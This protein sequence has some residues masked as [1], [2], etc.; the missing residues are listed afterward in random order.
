MED[1]EGCF[2]RF[3]EEGC[4]VLDQREKGHVMVCGRR[5]TFRCREMVMS[6]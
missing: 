3:V 4:A 6:V 2:W 1:K 5:G